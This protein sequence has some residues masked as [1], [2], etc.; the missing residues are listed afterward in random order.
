M[1]R[2]PQICGVPVA[3]GIVPE[4]AEVAS[5]LEGGGTVVEFEAEESCGVVA[6]DLLWR[7]PRGVLSP[8]DT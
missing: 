8:K 3:L 7:R 4:L 1:P 2:L 5:E 6:F